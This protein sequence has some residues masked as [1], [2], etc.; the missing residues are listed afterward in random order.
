VRWF[1][2][3]G[4]GSEATGVAPSRMAWGTLEPHDETVTVPIGEGRTRLAG[5]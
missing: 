3:D 2:A 4:A 1:P 5:S